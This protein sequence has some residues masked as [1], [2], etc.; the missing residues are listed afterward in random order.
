MQ[1]AAQNCQP[2]VTFEA[3]LRMVA[4]IYVSAYMAD[5]FCR[6]LSTVDD[7]YEYRLLTEVEWEAAL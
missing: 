4:A 5:M 6:W 7:R 3:D 2:H 1:I